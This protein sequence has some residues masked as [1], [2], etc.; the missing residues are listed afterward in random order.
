MEIRG[1]GRP[2]D[3]G[4]GIEK[5]PKTDVAVSGDS[6]FIGGSKSMASVS[7]SALMDLFK[8]DEAK[9]K[10]DTGSNR[11][12]QR[13]IM[14]ASDGSLVCGSGGIIR[15]IDP[16]DGKIKWEKNFEKQALSLD[17]SPASEG[18]DGCI[19]VTTSD[20][21]LRALDPDSGVEQ[22]KYRT[23]GQAYE[24]AVGSD[25]TIY[26]RS[27]GDLCALYPDGKERFKFP[28][29]DERHQVRY[30]EGAGGVLLESDHGIFCINGDGSERWHVPG[31]KVERFIGDS[32]RVYTMSDR[33]VKDEQNPGLNALNNTL[34]ARDPQT[35]DK[36]WE[37]DFKLAFV[38]EA[39]KGMVFIREPRTL[40]GLESD[41]GD[42]VWSSESEHMRDIKMMLP[43]GTLIV[44]GGGQV[45]A[46]NPLTGLPKWSVE[47]GESERENPIILTKRGMLLF[48]D[49]KKIYGVNPEDGQLTYRHYSD[50]PI[51]DF[52]LSKDEST[53]FIKEKDSGVVQGIDFRPAAERAKDLA[54]KPGA[55]EEKPVITIGDG[56]VDIDG[57]HLPRKE[58]N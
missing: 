48:N 50:G 47:T 17:S 10:T 26:T 29:E 8:P 34:I 35:G 53:I 51:E 25:G 21:Y 38:Q 24:P 23:E 45:E 54:Q 22:W 3:N 9:W 28:V 49:E 40:Y 18:N 20:H 30:I 27:K 37:K 13:G 57:V 19:L 33:W 43:D 36:L 11:Y 56:F 31:A 52:R 2:F 1:L 41:K 55:E 5:P 14:A 15:K 7:R 6:V 16:D 4:A 32:E 46:L 44:R 39:G 58:E 42:V 12:W